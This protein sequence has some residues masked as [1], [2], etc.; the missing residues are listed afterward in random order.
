MFK[1]KGNLRLLLYA[2]KFDIWFKDAGYLRW[3]KNFDKQMVAILEFCKNPGY[4]STVYISPVCFTHSVSGY[5]HELK[6]PWNHTEKHLKHPKNTQTS[7]KD[8]WNL[9]IPFKLQWDVIIDE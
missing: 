6:A 4:N 7:S 3:F 2:M 5:S 9:K 8:R 1:N